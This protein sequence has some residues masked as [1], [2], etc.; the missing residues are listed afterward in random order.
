MSSFDQQRERLEREVRA[1]KARLRAAAGDSSRS[2]RASEDDPASLHEQ[3][4]QQI[5]AHPGAVAA[6]AFGVVSV[7]GPWR[8]VRLASKAIGAAALVRRLTK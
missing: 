5:M 2:E 6:V 1:R 8:S 4:V 7:F 3:F